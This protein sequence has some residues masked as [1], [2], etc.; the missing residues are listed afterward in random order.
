M[1][2]SHVRS[3]RVCSGCDCPNHYIPFESSRGEATDFGLTF[4][5]L[6]HSNDAPSPSEECKLRDIISA[7][8]ARVAAIDNHV[9]ALKELQQT[10]SNHLS[11]IGVELEGLE[12]ER[13]K[14][15]ARIAEHKH[16]LSPVRRL[17]PEILF[18]I[19]LGTIIFPMRRTVAQRDRYWWN[20]HPS[21]SALWTIELV[22]KTWH[23]AVLDFPELWSSI[24][25]PLSDEN[26]SSSNLRYLRQLARQLARTRCHP[27][28]ILICSDSHQKLESSKSFP[29]QLSALLFA[30]QDR[31]QYLYLYLPPAMFTAVATLQLR[32]PILRKLTLLSTNG[33]EFQKL[34]RMKLFGYMP[35]LNGLGTVDIQSVVS[36]LD[37]P[38]HQITH[39]STSHVF[40]HSRNPGP[41][42]VH[43]LRFLS[44]TGNMEACNLRCEVK[45]KPETF[46]VEDLSQTCSKLQTLILSSWPY[47]YP[48]SVLA[49]LLNVLTLPRLSTLE[50]QCRV[51][52][53]HV[54]DTVETFAAIRG[55]ICRSQSPLTTF[56]FTHGDIDEEDLLALFLGASSTLEEVKLL[57][58]GPKALTDTILTPL[59]M[60]DADNV[61]LPRLHT[62]HISG[63]MQFDANLLAEMVES[64]WTCK[65][66]SFR[67][68]RTIILRRS[69][70]I[71]DDR[72]EV[73]LGSTLAFSKLEEY[74][75]EGLNLSYSIL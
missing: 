5:S 39:Y 15:V 68:L 36:V 32:L 51:D 11:S 41:S 44:K 64:R 17:P 33:E 47:E 70:D 22:C 61:L 8:K 23:R 20:F 73:E 58:V 66:P 6:L 42:T 19:F 69:L 45:A 18:K 56:H 34:P 13:G 38:Y 59:V 54:R 12:S 55:A 21:E 57:D 10:L 7:G 72:E 53:G 63:E 49:Q 30:A 35:L 71:E 9:A 27:L 1:M 75:T 74:C 43:I 46:V 50:V 40:H 37:L 29:L 65:G 16:L 14:V 67:R 2:L 62:L 24:N 48:S 26:F 60:T 28:S 4:E 52:E 31:I 25:I 3:P